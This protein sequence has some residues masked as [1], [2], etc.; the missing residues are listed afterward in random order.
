MIYLLIN[1][2]ISSVAPVF[3]SWFF[4]FFSFSFSLLFLFFFP[5]IFLYGA[6]ELNS[7]ASGGHP[8]IGSVHFARRCLRM[9]LPG[10]DLP[11]HDQLGRLLAGSQLADPHQKP[12]NYF[13]RPRWICDRN[14]RKYR[15]H[16]CGILK[17]VNIGMYCHLPDLSDTTLDRNFKF[18]IDD[19]QSIPIWRLFIDFFPTLDSFLT[20]YPPPLPPPMP[21]QHGD[22]HS[23][24]NDT[25]H[26]GLFSWFSWAPIQLVID[27]VNRHWSNWYIW[28]QKEE[29]EYDTVLIH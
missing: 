17:Y 23:G 24:S 26:L 18:I 13:H 21:P 12:H 10:T 9:F 27:V 7:W 8:Q 19:I 4:L 6:W 14:L 2:F 15:S 29:S 11:A 25:L 5:V 1:Y 28:N 16:R 22:P 3:N 20:A